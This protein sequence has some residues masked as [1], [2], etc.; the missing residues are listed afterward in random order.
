MDFILNDNPQDGISLS[1]NYRS[2]IKEIPSSEHPI[3]KALLS[4]L[5]FHKK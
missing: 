3:I 1:K 5:D 2:L 4:N